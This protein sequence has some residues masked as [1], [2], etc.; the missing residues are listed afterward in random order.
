[1]A[2][3]EKRIKTHR[4]RCLS[5][6]KMFLL[7]I[8]C[9]F[10]SKTLSG[11]Y[12]NSMLTQIERQ[13]NI[14]TSLVGFINGSFE[15]GNLLLIIF[16]SYF[17]TKL[18]RPILI[19]VG[20]VV[21]GLGCFLQSLPH[22]LM[23]RLSSYIWWFLVIYTYL[24]ERNNTSYLELLCIYEYESTVS[25]SGN[26]SSNSFLCMENGTQIIRPTEDP[27]ECVKEVKSLMW[28]YVLVGNIIRG[29]GETPIMPLGISYIEDFA[30]S[31]NSPLYI[32][33]VETGAIIGPLFGLSL[34]SF[35]A[36]VYVDTGSVNTDDLTITP[37]DTRW[38]GA[39]W[40]GFLIC[41]GV[42]VLTAIPFFFLP[43]WLPKEGL[44][45]NADIIKS[46]KEEKQREEVKKKKDGITKDFLPFMKS[47]LCNPVYMLFILISIIQFNAFVN[48]FTFMPKYLEQ[49]HGKSASDVIF[50]IVAGITTTYKGM[51]Q[52]LYME[53][54]ILADCNRDCNCPTK[55]WDPVCGNN[56]VSYMSAC[57][58]GCETSVGAG[59]NM[60][61]QNCSCIQTSGNSSAVLGLC[62]K[63]HDCSMML[64]YFLILSAIGSFIYSLS[65]IPGY[66]VLLRC[67]KPEEKS[68]GVGLHTFCTRVFAGIPAPIY[69]GAL[70]DST[71][72]H[73]GTLKCGESGA[74]RIYDSANF[75]YIYLGLPAALRGLSYI[76]AFLILNIL[77][78][79]H[80]PGE[81]AS[82]GTILTEAKTTKKENEC[83]DMDQNSKVLNDNELKTKL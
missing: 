78:N 25:V 28:M 43:K 12:M 41:A 74:C 55:T 72:L 50:L 47:L 60:V 19:G 14:P 34:A 27:S 6:M 71:C 39:W 56:G 76:P 3:N 73:W 81:N 79:R 37:T 7:A 44:K 1:M 4:I 45:S 24:R 20:C 32:G 16:V 38:V 46:D 31:E 61:F 63:G 75:R 64:Q 26:L 69:F 52:D 17:G 2:E 21:M 36:N 58:A 66:M 48:M 9:A 13:F 22:F 80:L 54:A 5:K 10:V 11:S 59:I 8:T 51:Q 62:D 70:V 33:F 82:S 42:N 15:I 68:L 23:E 49:Q 53:N 29:I 77:K 40:F 57:L 67:I 30:K 83:K 65:A 18:H 35:C